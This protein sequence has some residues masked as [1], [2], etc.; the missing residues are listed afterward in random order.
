MTAPAQEEIRA[1]KY[2]PAIA[3]ARTMVADASRER[4]TLTALRASL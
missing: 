3:L 2:P 1:G 4:A